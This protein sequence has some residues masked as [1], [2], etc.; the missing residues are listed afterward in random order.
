VNT[1]AQTS[2][3]TDDWASLVKVHEE[4]DLRVTVCSYRP[5]WHS[6]VPMATSYRSRHSDLTAT[7]CAADL[8]I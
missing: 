5:Q 3:N 1:S 4:E 6:R 2:Q 8:Q 7:I